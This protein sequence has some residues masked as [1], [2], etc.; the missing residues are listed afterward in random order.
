MTQAP[1]TYT[2]QQLVDAIHYN[3]MAYYHDDYQPGDEDYIS[4]E[5]YR[6]MLMEYSHSQ[7][8]EETCAA[9]PE[10]LADYMYLHEDN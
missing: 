7:L 1:T 4:P 8:V 2:H 10:E 5:E 6:E 9:T 3:F